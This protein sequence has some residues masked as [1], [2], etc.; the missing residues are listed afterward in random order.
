M[1]FP[2]L[3]AVALAVLTA[4]CTPDLGTCDDALARTVVYDTGS[5]PHYAGQAQLTASCEL[6]HKS[7]VGD[8][9]DTSRIGRYGAPHDLN[10]DVD[11]ADGSA[12]DT[13]RLRVGQLLSY[14]FRYDIYSEVAS[15][16]MPPVLRNSPD[17]DPAARVRDYAYL[18][19]TPLESLRTPEGRAIFRNWLSCGLP[20]VERTTRPEDAR[21]AGETPIGDVL[22]I[23]SCDLGTDCAAPQA[24]RVCANVSGTLTCVL[25]PDWRSIY[26]GFIE[27]NC[28]VGGCHADAGHISGLTMP[29][30][31]AAAAR[32]ALVGQASTS[33]GCGTPG[34]LRIEAGH[35]ETSLFLAKLTGHF[36]GTTT[37]QCG[38]LMPFGNTS[39]LLTATDPVNYAALRQWI[40]A[41]A[42]P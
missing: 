12:T 29:R 1:R 9:F 42:M 33:G 37:P 13:Q 14:R 36:D 27:P 24:G 8:D 21:P 34:L 41:G 20:V 40:A 35:P 2:T 23:A 39:P 18:D 38:P 4:S 26:T 7:G 17:P 5:L 15:G 25:K 28:A 32:T 30:G 31:D 16:T 10:W 22:P 19:G 3:F 6:C 11:L